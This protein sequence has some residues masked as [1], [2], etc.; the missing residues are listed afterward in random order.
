M[1]S[2]ALMAALVIGILIGWL[3]E[4]VTNRRHGIVANLLV[5]LTGSILGTFLIE[6]VTETYHVTLM[7]L[8]ASVIGSIF[9][10]SFLTLLK[11]KISD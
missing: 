1:I 5:G 7:T 6:S 2:V 11:R 10:L 9:L 3:S 4:R 8:S